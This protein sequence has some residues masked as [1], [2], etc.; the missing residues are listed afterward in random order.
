MTLDQFH[1]LVNHE[2]GLLGVSEISADLRDLFSRQSDDVRAAEAVELFCYRVKIGL[3]AMAAALGGLDTLVFAGGIGEN[4]PE[5]RRRICG[6]LEFLGINLDERRNRAG[7]PLVSIDGSRVA[8]RVIP[9][10]EESMIARASAGLI[11]RTRS[12]SDRDS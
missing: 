7:A 2:S 6:G 11:A 10:D 5:A 8:V 3:G 12:G 1:D 4:S 9:T